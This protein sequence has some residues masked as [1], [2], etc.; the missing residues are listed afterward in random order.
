MIP[1]RA[2]PLDYRY[3]AA[4]LAAAP[5]FEAETLYVIGGL[6][7]NLAAL[8]EIERMAACEPGPV[9]LV[10]NG[11]FHW[12]DVGDARFAAI[13]ERVLAHRAT[14]GNVEAELVRDEPAAGCGCA[15]PDTVDQATVE[16]S[17]AIHARLRATA[18][19]HPDILARLTAL[20]RFAR[21]RVGQAR[22]GLVHGDADSLAGWGFDVAALECE[23]A[24]ERLV[25]R[26]RAAAVD[27]FACSHTCLPVMRESRGGGV[28]ANN[29][30]AGMPNFDDGQYG[31]ITR[32]SKHASPLPTLYGT[33]AAE[34]HIDALAVHYDAAR[35]AADFLAD[36]PPGSP[37]HASYW[38][39]IAHG[40][41]YRIE[42]ARPHETP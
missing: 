30:A 10:F 3:G 18:A 1:G 14:A 17:N 16:R 27:V 36:W 15:Y 21:C 37:A 11:D 31:V 33:R 28:V 12:F 19:H 35:F 25:A 6:Y 38:S 39:R 40:T 2:C 41:R 5:E 29:G 13:D 4:A 24:E 9:T 8:D 32:I 22:I 23:G 26:F 34:A 7:G 42:R 20:P